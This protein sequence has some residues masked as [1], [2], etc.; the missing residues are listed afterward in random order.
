MARPA[1]DLV[2]KL[3]AE[4]R[5][6]QGMATT[7]AQALDLISRSQVQINA[8]LDDVV[9]STPFNVPPFTQIYS[10][11][12]SF[13]DCVRILSVRD[14]VGRDQIGRAHV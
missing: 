6:P 9:I 1:K 14:A 11:S 10:I 7:R 2:D 13:P 4:V 8:A 5:D 3:L 12:G